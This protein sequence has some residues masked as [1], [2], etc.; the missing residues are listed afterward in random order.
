[1]ELRIYYLIIRKWLWL[2]LLCTALASFSAFLFSIQQTT[3]YEADSKVLL[4]NSKPTTE[5]TTIDNILASNRV[6]STYAELFASR[7]ALE[8][9][10]KELEEER[11]KGEPDILELFVT[12]QRDTALLELRVES[13]DIEA[14]IF[15]ANRLPQVVEGQQRERQAKRYKAAREQFEEQLDQIATEIEQINEKIALLDKDASEINRLEGDLN[16]QNITYQTVLQD[17]SVI[18]LAEIENA[19][20][21]SVV[22]SAVLPEEPIR[23]RL[24]LNTLLAAIVGAIVGLGV[25]FLREYLDDTIK[26]SHNLK[27]VFGLNVLAP[28]GRIEGEGKRTLV[29]T[30]GKRSRMAEAYRML[31]T[32]LRFVSVDKDKDKSMK[33]LLI[34]SPKPGEGKS[35][36]AANLAVVLAQEDKDRQVILVDADL[37][38]PVQQEFFEIK[39]R[40]GLTNALADKED[41][42]EKY[43]RQYKDPKLKNL[44]ILPCGIKP[45]NPS[46]LLGS[47]RMKKLLDELQK[48]AYYVII[49][50]PPVLAVSDTSVLAGNTQCGVLLVLRANQTKYEIAISAIE[51]LESVNAKPLGLI[52]NDV[53]DSGDGYYYYYY[54]K[55]YYTDESDD[56]D[57]SG[58]SNQSVQTVQNQNAKGSKKKKKNRSLPS[59][60]TAK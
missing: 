32:N 34:T 27:E 56:S 40:P 43:L 28:I 2:I 39:I 10:L 30:L 24:L 41:T 33:T 11:G 55:S 8:G 50:S 45:P 58:D 38:R 25:G 16:L 54:D 3:V 44:R 15:I 6:V 7:E 13:N 17:I 18:Q 51:Q 21:L 47:E 23:P 46:E 53:S 57:Q 20:L 14:A 12:P 29:H 37:R 19:N 42:V 49:D 31:R 48:L 22:E 59:P 4:D 26:A 35:T 9:V 60:V 52:L 5:S 1:M 36:T